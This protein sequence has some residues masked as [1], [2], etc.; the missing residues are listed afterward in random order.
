MTNRLT[1]AARFARLPLIAI[2]RGVR[3]DEV[4]G[5]GEALVSAGFTLIEV[6]LNS[7]EPLDS[8]SRLAAHLG[9]RAMV[10]AGTVLTEPDVAAVAA[11]GGTMIIAPNTDPRVIAAADRAGLVPIPGFSTPSEAFAALQ[12]GAAALKLFPAEGSSPVA[13]KA[14]RAVIP[15]D[16]A[17]LPVG[18]ITPAVMPSWLAAGA[19]GFGLGSALYRAG[20]AAGVVADRAE[21]FVAAWRDASG[22]C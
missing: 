12:A 1:F 6:P 22:P 19:S 9:D 2:L 16:R 5:V 10:G 8:V 13:L 4:I 21:R 17:I 7:P 15:A 3:P 18:G 14:V 20:D 11:A